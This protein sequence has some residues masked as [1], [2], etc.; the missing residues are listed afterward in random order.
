MWWHG[1]AVPANASRATP[2]IAIT[3][4]D[5]VRPCTL[6]MVAAAQEITLSISRFAGALMIFGGS[7]NLFGVPSKEWSGTS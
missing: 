5:T 1:G 7:H 4:S 2:H 3:F 6:H